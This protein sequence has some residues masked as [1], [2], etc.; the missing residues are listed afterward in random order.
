MQAATLIPRALD[1]VRR[2]AHVCGK[3]HVSA[4]DVLAAAM[5]GR[6]HRHSLRSSIALIPWIFETP[7]NI[8]F[9]GTCRSLEDPEEWVPRLSRLTQ[10]RLLLT[11]LRRKFFSATL[12]SMGSIFQPVLIEHTP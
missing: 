12:K 10:T 1:Q 3:E 2:S 8:Q 11:D 7:E 6:S 5:D 4:A 9:S